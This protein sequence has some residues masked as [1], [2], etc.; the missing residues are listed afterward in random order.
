MIVIKCEYVLRAKD[1]DSVLDDLHEQAKN[2]IVLL[3][4]GFDLVGAST[5]F[6]ILGINEKQELEIKLLALIKGE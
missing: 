2:G 3:P 5:P 6:K 4:Q 1:Y